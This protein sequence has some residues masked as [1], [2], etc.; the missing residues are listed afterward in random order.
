MKIRKPKVKYYPIK[1]EFG[2]KMCRKCNQFYP[3]TDYYRHA[4]YSYLDDGR[5]VICRHCMSRDHY[6]RK[7]TEKK[8]YRMRN[9]TPKDRKDRQKVFLRKFNAFNWN[10]HLYKT[11]TA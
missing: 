6:K 4:S 9:I 11:R 8:F 10:N 7:G 2:E 1:N 5:T 3:V